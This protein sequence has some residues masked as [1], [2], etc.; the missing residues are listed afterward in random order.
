M[1]SS[2]VSGT[3]A[4]TSGF[5]SATGA[6]G[7]TSATSASVSMSI[8]SAGAPPKA[9]ALIASINEQ[10]L[11]IAQLE[12][13]NAHCK[14]DV[15]R[16]KT[17]CNSYKTRYEEAT[18]ITSSKFAE[19]NKRMDGLEARMAHTRR[20]VSTT[21]SESDSSGEVRIMTK[22]EQIAVEASIAAF[23]DTNLLVSVTS[24]HVF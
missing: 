10:N 22:K 6:S 16:I 24:R 2:H 9:A 11:R 12:N 20:S 18:S 23:S 5:G 3:S 15:D 8:S 21:G 14:S 4:S 17:W 19:M 1:S 13:E 7:T